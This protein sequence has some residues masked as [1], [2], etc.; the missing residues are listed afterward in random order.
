LRRSFSS[1]TVLIHHRSLIRKTCLC[2]FLAVLANGLADVSTAIG[3]EEAPVAFDIPAQPLAGALSSWAVQANA[4]VFFEQAPVAGLNAPAVTG[5]LPP[6]DALRA[7]LAHSNLEFTQNLQGAFVI[8]RKHVMARHAPAA[9][10]VTASAVPVEIIPRPQTARAQTVRDLEGP[11]V[12]RLRGIY[13][14]PHRGS[15]A[16]E[17]T[18]PREVFAPADATHVD[19]GWFPELDLEYFFTSRWSSELAVG[20]PSAHTLSLRQNSFV[21]GSA[22]DFR[23]LPGFATVKYNF[24]PDSVVRPY[25]GIGLNWTVFY[26][27]NAA[28]FGLSKSVVGP[29]AQAGLDIALGKRWVFNADLKWAR[30]RSAVRFDQQLA[31]QVQID[32]LFLAIG[33]GYRFGTPEAAPVAVSSVA[34]SVPAPAPAPT[35]RCPN[36]PKGVPV[37]ANGCPLD[38]DGDGVPDY[39]DKCPGTPPG[40]RVDSNGCELQEWVLRGVTFETN[41]ATLTSQSSLTLDAVVAVVAQRPNAQVEVRGYTDSRGSD[42]YNLAL[43]QR[44]AA[45]VVAYFAAHGIPAARQ[46]STGLGKIN[47]IAGNDTAEGRA[48][49][50][51]VT[52]RFEQPILR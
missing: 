48:Q 38:S 17:L 46:S 32:P 21:N 45:A 8:R 11:W 5:N 9:S 50:R 43:S 20:L 42:A 44:R 24:N 16:L 3:A 31:G 26:D 4:Q 34:P 28:P 37:D 27:L 12:I 7:L 23:L 19:G 47:P 14:Y 49:N 6:K 39:L 15:D 51:R 22:G 36:T 40:V 35:S 29:A 30:I 41:S 25:V 10:A 13:M 18:R 2:V 1:R 52:L 33:F